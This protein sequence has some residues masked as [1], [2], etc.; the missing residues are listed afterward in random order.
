MR[1]KSGAEAD[2]VGRLGLGKPHRG[3]WASIRSMED[4]F[5]GCAPVR[6]VFSKRIL[7]TVM[8]GELAWR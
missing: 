1:G 4:S 3:V 7:A 6:F 2:W 8:A 5:Q